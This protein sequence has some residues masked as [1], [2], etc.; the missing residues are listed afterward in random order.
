M[1]L[2]LDFKCEDLQILGCYSYMNWLFLIFLLK[3]TSKTTKI[4]ICRE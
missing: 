1:I 4:R 3:V 2:L